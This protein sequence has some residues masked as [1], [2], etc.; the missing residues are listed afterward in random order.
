MG[1]RPPAA[2]IA[3]F[4]GP[5]R[6]RTDLYPGSWENPKAGR[7]GYAPAC[8]KEWQPGL[9]GKP[10]INCTVCPNQAFLP[11]TNEMIARHLKG[12]D[13][14]NKPFVSG[15]YPLLPDDQCAFLAADFDEGDWQRDV[16]AFVAVCRQHDLPVAIERSRSGKGAHAWLFFAQPISAVEARRLG[17]LMI[18]RTLDRTPDLGFK[19]YDRL[20]PSQNH[21]AEGGLGNLIALP[22]QGTARRAGNSVFV[23]D[24]L[25]PFPDQWAFL[26][27]QHRIAPSR[28]D[29]LVEEGSRTGGILS[30]RLPTEDDDAEPWLLP[31]SRRK[32]VPPPVYWSLPAALTIVLADQLYI[33]RGELPP[34]MVTHLMRAAVFQNPEFYEVQALR[35]STYGKLRIISCAELTSRHVGLPRGCMDAALEILQ[36]AGI[37]VTL[38]DER[39]QGTLIQVTF[40]VACCV[41]I[42]N[43]P[44]RRWFPTT[45][46]FWPPRRRSARRCSRRI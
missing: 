19:S 11:T 34:Q 3:L 12:H 6:G 40:P 7:S 27:R 9:C 33:P 43:R 23:D 8:A 41:R 38:R 1:T 17:A 24:N 46:G 29:A 16:R 25:A 18:T 2:K 28:V 21:R 31:P 32:A 42:N 14:H 30:V 39:T 20:V 37:A 10:V 44:Q 4:R 35:L 5:F 45:R 36:A 13:D 22:L 15:V 26:A